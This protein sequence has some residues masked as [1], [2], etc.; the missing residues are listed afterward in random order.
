MK[1]NALALSGNREPR[2]NTPKASMKGL[3]QRAIRDSFTKLDPRTAV[4]TPVM[5]LVWVATIVTLLVTLDPNLFGTVAADVGQQRL[6]NGTI[7]IILFM[8]VMFANFAEA[9]RATY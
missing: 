5:F 4:G 3:Y 9:V 8:T 6:L 7:T 1:S 2:R